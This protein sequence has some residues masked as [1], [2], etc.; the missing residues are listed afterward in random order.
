MPSNASAQQ[1]ISES[2]IVFYQGT[3]VNLKQCLE[4]QQQ[5]ENERQNIMDKN[6]QLELQL[7][8]SYL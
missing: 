5:I 7:S 8:K 4:Q 3:L 2:G 1:N 6:D